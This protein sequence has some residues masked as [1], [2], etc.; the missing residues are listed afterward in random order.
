[1]AEEAALL[2]MFA[3]Q[4]EMTQI[5]Q[6]ASFK[7][8]QEIDSEKQAVLNASKENTK[9]YLSDSNDD[10]D[11]CFQDVSTFEKKLYMIMIPHTLFWQ[12]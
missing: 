8:Q 7:F 6:F 9:T 4:D 11:E 12:H 2:G 5:I 1:V 3:S 10:S